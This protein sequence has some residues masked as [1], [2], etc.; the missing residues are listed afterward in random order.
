MTLPDHAERLSAAATEANAKMDVEAE[1]IYAIVIVF[2]KRNLPRSTRIL[3]KIDCHV[4]PP[5]FCLSFSSRFPHFPLVSSTRR[6]IK[7]MIHAGINETAKGRELTAPVLSLA[8]II[9]VLTSVL[10]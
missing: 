5:P 10:S 4:A 8:G 9:V 3:S 1:A 2:P 6:M 7:T